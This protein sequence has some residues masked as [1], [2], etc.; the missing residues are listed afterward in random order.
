MLWQEDESAKGTVYAFPHG[1]AVKKLQDQTWI[2]QPSYEWVMA[3]AL[4]V[5]GLQ[6]LFKS[7]TDESADISP[8]VGA[9]DT[10]HDQIARI[11]CAHDPLCDVPLEIRD[12]LLS[13]LGSAGIANLRL[14]SRAFTHL[15]ISLWRRLVIKEMPWLWEA[16]SDAI[17]SYWATKYATETIIHQ[18]LDHY[19]YDDLEERKLTLLPIQWAEDEARYDE[20]TKKPLSR[21]DS[22]V[23]P[24][25]GTNWY[26]LFVALKGPEKDLDKGLRNRRRIWRDVEEI[27]KQIEICR[28][29][30]EAS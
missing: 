8:R 17:P 26:K 27:V 16:W 23:L 6:D 11:S 1:P 28:A 15:P 14:A 25:H 7:C 22:L 21:G 5:P 24:K 12:E 30:L 29:R 13:Y 18:Q 9:L 3:N 2:C 4:Y 10:A 20:T 19:E